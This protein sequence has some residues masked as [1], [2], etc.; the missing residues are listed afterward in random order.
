MTYINHKVNSSYQNLRNLVNSRGVNNEIIKDLCL[1][2]KTREQ[3]AKHLIIERIIDE[4]RTSRSQNNTSFHLFL[5]LFK[6]CRNT[7]ELQWISR[8]YMSKI[9]ETIYMKI[10]PE[11][12]SRLVKV[13]VEKNLI[14]HRVIVTSRC[15]G[16][17][18]TRLMVAI[19]WEFLINNFNLGF[20]RTKK[21]DIKAPFEDSSSCL[22]TS[23]NS[24][25]YINNNIIP[26]VSNV[27]NVRMVL[28]RSVEK[29]IVEADKHRQL[30]DVAY[31]KIAKTVNSNMFLRNSKNAIHARN[32]QR[33]YITR[34]VEDVI[35]K[36]NV[37]PFVTTIKKAF[38]FNDM[39]DVDERYYKNLLC[40]LNRKL[41][42][43]FNITLDHLDYKLKYL[44]K[45]PKQ[46]VFLSFEALVNYLRLSFS[47]IQDW[48][49]RRFY[50]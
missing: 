41:H 6:K 27:E 28:E 5:G 4:N 46:P 35:M 50:A 38:G 12:I 17:I 42:H 39:H 16:Q 36:N 11:R 30:S 34:I 33:K 48:E 31:K 25:I 2:A 45:A 13:L 26:V 10:T 22:S 29:H 1:T 18:K 21:V 47:K 23:I 32:K 7:T 9:L 24:N 20:K 40:Q 19:N 8:D 37:L 15:Q 14:I 44:Q 49:Y 3:I 43:R